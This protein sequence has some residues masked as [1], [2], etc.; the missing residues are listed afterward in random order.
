MVSRISRDF[1]KAVFPL[2]TFR[3][4]PRHLQSLSDEK[5]RERLEA[6]R[7]IQTVL[8]GDTAFISRRIPVENIA[9]SGHSCWK[10]RSS[11]GF[12]WKK[13]ESGGQ[14]HLP[15]FQK[16]SFAESS[17]LGLVSYISSKCPNRGL[18]RS[19]AVLNGRTRW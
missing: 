16:K 9:F 13:R 18:Q 15:G 4:F 12:L 3:T 1:M 11:C 2:G 14:K 19:Y 6:V 10:R 5:S 17:A 8:S 7:K